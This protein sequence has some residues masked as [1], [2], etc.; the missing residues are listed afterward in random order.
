MLFF[1]KTKAPFF[2]RIKG[3]F[4]LNISFIITCIPIISIGAS[5]TA[6][7][8]VLF[9]LQEDTNMLKAYIDRFKRN[10]KESTI[11][12]A[13]ILIFAVIVYLDYALLG[14]LSTSFW[15][16][17]IVLY[18]DV[19]LVVGVSTYAFGLISMF[20]N[21]IKQTLKNALIFCLSMP[22]KTI[23]MV[24]VTMVPIILIL[25]DM[26]ILPVVIVFWALFGIEISAEINAKLLKDIFAS[27]P[28][29]E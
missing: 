12:W 4:L 27:F 29:E 2:E 13:I 17:S 8:S 26:S 28:L 25:V 24:M 7:Y 9:N 22:I 20:R 3:I 11:I 10:F 18:I 1:G 21:T 19:Y 15:V 14:Y 5:I 23:Y 6:L 16:V